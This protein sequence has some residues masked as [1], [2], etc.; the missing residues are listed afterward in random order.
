MPP[1]A[2]TFYNLPTLD[3]V[4]AFMKEMARVLKP[5]GR[6]I[7]DIRNRWNLPI[8]LRF[9]LVR[10][11]DP[12]YPCPLRVYSLSELDRAARGTS[13]HPVRYHRIGLLKSPLCPII[14]IEMERTS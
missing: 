1:P 2:N 7:V 3:M 14:V 11:H 6:C 5:G 9:K 4:G 8:A 10:W 12:T 13:L